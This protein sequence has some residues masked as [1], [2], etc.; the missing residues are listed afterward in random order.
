MSCSYSDVHVRFHTKSFSF[1]IDWSHCVNSCMSP[2]IHAIKT[3]PCDGGRDLGGWMTFAFFLGLVGDVTGNKYDAFLGRVVAGEDDGALSWALEGASKDGGPLI[4]SILTG[5]DVDRTGE[6]L[7]DI[8]AVSTP[9]KRPRCSDDCRSGIGD[10]GVG[11][12]ARSLVLTLALAIEG[13]E[14]RYSDGG[15]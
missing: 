11:V 3:V 5:D 14:G 7:E 8:A 9:G 6:Y 10:R 4:I 13:G 1:T 12:T 15:R 2:S